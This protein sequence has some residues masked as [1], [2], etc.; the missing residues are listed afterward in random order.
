MQGLIEE[1]KVDNFNI[2]QYTPCP[3][4]VKFEVLKEGSFAVNKL[5]VSQVNWH[6][7]NNNLSESETLDDGGYNVAKCMRA[8]AEPLLVSHFGEGIIEEVFRRY[9]EIIV[10]RMSKE[11]T[12]FFNVTISMTKRSSA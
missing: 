1:E 6:A 11:K 5:E 4:E 2:P 9:R 10:D 12:E 7:Y 8:V 3:S